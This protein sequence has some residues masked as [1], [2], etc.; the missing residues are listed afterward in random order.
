M[1][2]IDGNRLKQA[3]IFL[4]RAMA[5]YTFGNGVFV[6][7]ELFK[8]SE[9]QLHLAVQIRAF[10]D[11]GEG[12][13]TAQGESDTVRDDVGSLKRLGLTDREA[14]ITD[15]L[16]RAVGIAQTVSVLPSGAAVASLAMTCSCLRETSSSSEVSGGHHPRR[17]SATLI[18]DDASLLRLAARGGISNDDVKL[19]SFAKA[20]GNPSALGRE[21][22]VLLDVS[23]DVADVLRM[24]DLLRAKN[25]V[26]ATLI[27]ICPQGQINESLAE[28][29]LELGFRGVIQKPLYYSRLIQVIR[30][31]IDSASISRGRDAHG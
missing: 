27:A 12:L 13:L 28:R 11:P 1:L 8:L 5:R 18:S 23:G 4:V 20:Y 10:Y 7:F 21:D 6:N 14:K 30:G 16:L 29:L 9:D 15:Y 2:D 19:V 25:E 26:R 24:L 31:T 17:I 3:I 22:A